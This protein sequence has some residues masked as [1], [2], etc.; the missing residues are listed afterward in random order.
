M[1]IFTNIAISCNVVEDLIH[2]ADDGLLLILFS[3]TIRKNYGV[4]NV[5]DTVLLIT[6][7]YTYCKS[8]MPRSVTMTIFL[9]ILSAQP[10]HLFSIYLFTYSTLVCMIHSGLS[11]PFLFLFLL[12]FQILT[13][14]I[15]V[16][17]G[18]YSVYLH[19]IYPVKK[20]GTFLRASLC[21]LRRKFWLLNYVIYLKLTFL[22]LSVKKFFRKKVSTEKLSLTKEDPIKSV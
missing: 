6:I 14:K 7:L 22:G 11:L 21:V 9:L 20:A 4:R 8:M 19:V 15:K 13:L 2:F 10:K 17:L 3:F 18:H 16:K 12:L 5:N 1:S